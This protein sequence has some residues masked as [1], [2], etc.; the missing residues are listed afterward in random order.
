MRTLLFAV[1]FFFAGTACAQIVSERQLQIPKGP[2]TTPARP[3]D[4][5]AQCRAQAEQGDA[6]AAFQMGMAALIGQG[7]TQDAKAAEQYFGKAQMTPGQ[8]CL[9]AETYMET[10]LA[11]REEAAERWLA[12][13]NSGCADWTR[14]HW[15]EGN[16]LG[17]N[18]AREAEY[19]RK[20]LAAKDNDYRAQAEALLGQML[21]EGRIDAAPARERAAWM[22]AAARARVGMA[23]A[24]VGGYYTQHPEATDDVELALASVKKSAR[25]GT[26]VSLTRLGQAA[27]TR[28]A[29]ELTYLEGM[30]LMAIGLRQQMFGAPSL[31]SALRQM[32]AAQRAELDNAIAMWERVAK[33]TGGYYTKSDPLRLTSPVDEAALS[34]QAA[35]SNPD[36][37]LRLAYVY[38]TKGDWSKAETIYREVYAHGQGVV[39][40]SVG[41]P[42]A[43][44]EKWDAARS[45]LDL[46]AGMGSRQACLRMAELNAEG[47]GSPKSPYNAYLWLMRAGAKDEKLLTPIRG[48]LHPDELKSVATT[49]AYW[50]AA[51]KAYWPEEAK[52][53][54]NLRT[55][56]LQVQRLTPAPPGS[57]NA[58]PPPKPPSLPALKHKA[59]AG[60]ADAAYQLAVELLWNYTNPDVQTIEHYATLGARARNQKSH[61]ADGYARSDNLSPAVSRKYAEKWYRAVGGS[62]GIY[63]LGKIFNGKSD[64]VVQSED[65]KKA[66]ALWQQSAAGGEERWARLSRM[67]LGY[68]VVK[69][70]SSGNRAN[71]ARWAHELAMEF[72]AKEWYQ[73]AGEYSYGH[74]LEHNRQTFDW[75]TERAASYNDGNAQSTLA[76]DMIEGNWK[77]GDDIDA[78]VWM[79]LEAVKQDTGQGKQVELAEQNPELKRKIEDR[80]ALLMKARAEAGAYYMQ[81]DPL[82]TATAAE[83]EPRAAALDPEAQFRLGRRLEEQATPEALERAIGLYRTLWSSSSVEVRLAWGRETMRGLYGVQRDDASALQWLTDAAN[84][85][86]HEACADLATMYAEGRGVQADPLAAEAWRRLADRAAQPSPSLTEAQQRAVQVRID[87]WLADHKGW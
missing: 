12:H 84:R 74:T 26:P 22:G 38:E 83:L 52:A 69:G 67:E 62:E 82:R 10:A 43:K 53:T 8:M 75:L 27:M 80:F 85:G 21:M 45:F 2:V 56:E 32:D 34:A 18:P 79:K 3:A 72:M 37:E 20:V 65:E 66:V 76:Q 59:D 39:F 15:W 31:A 51:H 54:E 28:E 24:A 9:V 57:G 35:A 73:V 25:Y 46:A 41:E 7:M 87:A 61:I 55:S 60:D 78:Y 14:A 50:Y 68:R 63:W 5:L 40:L 4:D 77:H 19:L 16:Q 11:G 42:L 17:P 23:E 71:D 49:N 33:E 13:A 29:P 81:D 64:G 44:A 86:S 1:L 6:D 48:A 47:K 70:W 36:A 58:P 30:A